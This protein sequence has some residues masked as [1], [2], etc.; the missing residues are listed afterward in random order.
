MAGGLAFSQQ[1]LWDPDQKAGSLP[2]TGHWEGRGWGVGA[3]GTL[4]SVPGAPGSLEEPEPSFS[5]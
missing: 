4:G 5:L 2:E 3:V 1:Q